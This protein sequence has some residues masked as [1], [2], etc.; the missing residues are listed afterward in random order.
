MTETDLTAQNDDDFPTSAQEDAYSQGL[1]L[2]AAAAELWASSAYGPDPA[3]GPIDLGEVAEFEA[4]VRA[5]T[6][7][8]STDDDSDGDC[9]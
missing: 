4:D 6:Y 5:G 9:R 1:V 3:A 8:T 7:D 2:S